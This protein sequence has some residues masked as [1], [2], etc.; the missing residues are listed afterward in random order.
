MSGTRRTENHSVLGS[1]VIDDEG[2][3]H[4]TRDV[5]PSII[6]T[7][8]NYKGRTRRS[9]RLMTTFQPNTTLSESELFV[10]L[11]WSSAEAL[12]SLVKGY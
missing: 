9:H 5:E 4:R 3:Q 11:A 7:V 10:I 12:D 6:R 2:A 1:E 8:S